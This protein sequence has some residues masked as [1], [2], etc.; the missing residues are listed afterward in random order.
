VT[1]APVRRGLTV[2]GMTVGVRPIV[3]AR[4]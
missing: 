2:L 3:V 1:D 4:G